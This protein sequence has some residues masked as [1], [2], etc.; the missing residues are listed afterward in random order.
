[1]SKTDNG[2]G[3]TSLSLGQPLEYFHAG[4]T[5]EYDGGAWSIDYRAEVAL[6]TRTVLFRGNSVPKIYVLS[7]NK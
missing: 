1:M 3:T 2:D 7:K 4:I 6:L 5:E